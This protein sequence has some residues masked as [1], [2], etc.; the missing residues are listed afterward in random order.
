MTKEPTKRTLA[1][2]TVQAM[3]EAATRLAQRAGEDTDPAQVYGC[4][5]WFR[6]DAAP[7]PGRA[8]T[9]PQPAASRHD[10]GPGGASSSH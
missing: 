10:G 1:N 5:D 4:V 8:D 2:R 9:R 7:P 3:R 6:Y